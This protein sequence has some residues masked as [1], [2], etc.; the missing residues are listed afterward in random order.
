MHDI[1]CGGHL[2]H[3]VFHMWNSLSLTI[4]LCHLFCG[5]KI[6]IAFAISWGQNYILCVTDVLTTFDV[7]YDLLLNRCTAIWNL[8]VL[9]ERN[10]LLQMK[11]FCSKSPK[12][13]FAH[14]WSTLN[15]L[16]SL[17][18]QIEAISLVALH[19]KETWLFHKN[20]ATVRLDLSVASGGN[21]TS[22][23]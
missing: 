7:L 15:L 17:S 14:F 22:R 10:K 18:I 19:S 13:A 1:T 16:C 5:L 2:W 9:Y 3:L 20:Y 21:N 8:F 6:I 4:G 23:A 12:Q 11:L